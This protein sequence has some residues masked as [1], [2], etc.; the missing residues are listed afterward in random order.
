MAVRP[1]DG[2][3]VL[4]IMAQKMVAHA[5]TEAVCEKVEAK[6]VSTDVQMGM[7]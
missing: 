7:L 4:V 2:Q 5:L 3:P 6:P 1:E